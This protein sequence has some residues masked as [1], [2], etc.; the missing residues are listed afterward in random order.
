MY[1]TVTV[2]LLVPASTKEKE[3][4]AHTDETV[5]VRRFT[6]EDIN[7]NTLRGRKTWGRIERWRQN[8]IL[9]FVELLRAIEAKDDLAI[10]KAS[11]NLKA[12]AGAITRAVVQHLV[13]EPGFA[14]SLLAKELS[15]QLD[16]VRIVLWYWQEQMAPALLCPDSATAMLLHVLMSA[17]G[18]SV[19]LRLCPKCG[20]PFLQKRRD[21]DYCSIKCREAHRV[22]RWRAASRR[23]AVSR[24][25]PTKKLPTGR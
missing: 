9:N 12:A 23:S 16:S 11:L 21:Q 24:R 3:G 2:Q 7:R 20:R 14:Q 10:E 5:P 1:K 19:G 6:D 22:A 8:Q 25:G 18:A 15:Q 17:V 13:R 4:V